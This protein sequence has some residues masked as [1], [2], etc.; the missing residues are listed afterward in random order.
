M[1][2]LGNTTVSGKLAVSDTGVIGDRLWADCLTTTQ[3]NGYIDFITSSGLNFGVYG[4]AGTV[5]NLSSLTTCSQ[6]TFGTAATY[7]TTTTVTSGSNALV[8]SDAVYQAIYG[9]MN[10]AV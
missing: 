6:G 4:V 2:D 10:T 1:A 3:N 9:A 8:T 5:Y 7:S